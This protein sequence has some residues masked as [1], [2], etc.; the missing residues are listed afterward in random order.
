MKENF[1]RVGY[2]NK[3]TEIFIIS[4]GIKKKSSL[5]EN[6]ATCFILKRIRINYVQEL[7]NFHFSKNEAFIFIYMLKMPLCAFRIDQ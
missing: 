3:K 6:S 7:N 4:Y 1:I 2:G 5:F